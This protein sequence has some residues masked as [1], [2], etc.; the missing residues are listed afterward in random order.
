MSAISKNTFFGRERELLQLQRLRSTVKGNAISRFVVVSG[1]RRVG[2][3]RLILEALPFGDDMPTIYVY[4]NPHLDA[5]SNLE[6]FSESLR[7][8]LGWSRPRRFHDFEDALMEVF[9]VAKQRP[10]TLVLDEFQ[11]FGRVEPSFYGTLQ[12]LW[13]LH[14]EK[15][16]L[17]LVVCG[18]VASSM[19]EIFENGQA[20]LFARNNAVLHV[21]PFLPDLVKT[22]FKSYCP[23]F[24][25]D[26]LLALYAFTGGVAQYIQNFLPMGAFT[27]EDMLQLGVE[28]NS[29]W[30][31]EA[32][33]MLTS[34]FKG[35]AQTYHEILRR[36]AA[37]KNKRAELIRSF[38]IDVSAHL[39]QLQHEYALIESLEPVGQNGAKRQRVAY[40]LNDEL[41][42]F[43]FTFILPNQR[44]LQSHNTQAIRQLILRDYPNRSGRVLERLYR[45]HFRNLGLFTQVGPWWDRNGT[46]EID[47]V[48]VDDLNRTVCF[49]EIK[50]NPAKIHL[51]ALKDKARVFLSFNPA[52]ENY[53]TLFLGLSIDELGSDKKLP[54]EK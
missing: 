43:W 52:L 47:C 19:R 46:N 3:T 33:L 22:V 26:D 6:D 21:E 2:K 44:I 31:S 16:Q 40:E 54:F 51:S 32:Q 17:L 34:E 1:R 8:C 29:V 9:E 37:G 45:R 4:I 36:I 35:S 20:P 14:H 49:A 28:E 12:K 5:E 30:L 41:L 23:N 42:D 50:R 7:E 25:G 24:S 15:M 53:Q 13:D 27:L 11:N 48:A 38:S 39:Y 18:S 10:I